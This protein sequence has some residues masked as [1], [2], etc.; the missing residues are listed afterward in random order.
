MAERFDRLLRRVAPKWALS[1]AQ[2]RLALD[3]VEMRYDAATT[4]RRA[5]SWS[6]NALDADAA[7]AQRQRLAMVARDMIRNTP[8]ATRAQQVITGNTVGDGII[9][10]VMGGSDRQRE[11]LRLTLEAHLDTVA[12]DAAGRNNLYGLQ[13]LAV[14][15]IVDAGEVLIR[16]RRRRASDGLPL[17][18][19]IEVLEPDY[20][21]ASLYGELTGGNTV[22]DGIEYDALGRRV[23]YYLFREHPGGRAWGRR[24]D[25]VRVPARDV[26]HVFRSDR[27]GQNRG[28]SWFAPVALRLQD[29]ADYQ[30]AQ[31][32][33]QKIAACFTAFRFRLDDEPVNGDRSSATR[34][35]TLQPGRVEELAPGEDIKFATPPGVEAYDEF[36]RGVLR[37]AAAGLG[38]TYEALT[39]DLSNV[40]FTS[41]R[42]GRMDMDRNVTAWQWTM[43]IP[44]MLH[45]LSGWLL[46]E[47]AYG[48]PAL[49]RDMRIGW[50]PPA[51]IIVDPAREIP[52]LI[53]KIRGGLTSRS[54]A[55]R[56]LGYDPERIEEEIARDNRVADALQLVLDSDPR[57]VAASGTAH[58]TPFEETADE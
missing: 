20:L 57:R 24:L 52:A 38:I 55:I 44:Q 2:A 45:P 11:D 47:F 28:V 23:A 42:M 39:G 16:R 50:V 10:K 3:Q 48:R 31:L 30:D 40:N 22:R 56:S 25:S 19:Q 35:A 37:E 53:R 4:G 7:G 9:P 33:R 5:S 21:D 18:M 14:N 34:F 6:L 58:S 43:L 8:F 29:L 13:R 54:D 15:T 27:P 17:N 12:I 26:L 46:E 36:T 1:R 41:G 32:M 49:P 51:R